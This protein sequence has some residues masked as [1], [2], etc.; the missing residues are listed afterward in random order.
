[1]DIHASLRQLPGYKLNE[2]QEAIIRHEQGPLLVIAGPGSGKTLTIILRALNLLLHGEAEPSQ[3]VICTYT[4]KAAH[5]LQSRFMDMAHKVHYQQ[6]LAEL[7]IGTIHSICN[8]LIRRYL[9]SAHLGNNYEVLDEF[10][11]RIFIF[12][13]LSDIL[14]PSIRRTIVQ[15]WEH[16]KWQ[17]AQ[18]LQDYFD[19]IMEELIDERAL[20]LNGDPF[21][22]ALSIAYTRYCKLLHTQNCVSFAAQLKTAHKLLTPGTQTYRLITQSIRYVFVDE[23]QDTNNI[24]ERIIL[25]LASATNNLCVIGDED[26]A[27]YRFRGATVRNI[28]EFSQQTPDCTVL[29]L[30]INYRSHKDIITAYATWMKGGKWSDGKH[31]FR[32][33]KDI[34]PD[35]DK[36]YLDYPSAIVLQGKDEVDETEQLADLILYLHEQRIITDY[37][38]IAFLLPSVRPQVSARYTEVF[39]RRG[40]PYFCPRARA[41]FEQEEVRLMVACFA[42]LF[43]CDGNDLDDLLADSA[44]RDFQDYLQKRCLSVLA[45]DYS[46]NHPLQQQ[47]LH[48][49]EDFKERI[50]TAEQIG[51]GKADFYLMD[52]FYRLLAVEPFATFVTDEQRLYN[53]QIFSKLLENF[54]KLYRP[55]RLTIETWQRMQH[56]FFAIYLRLQ[57]FEGLN[58]FEHNEQPFP[59]GHVQIMT[60]HQAKGLE[61]PVVIVGGMEKSRVGAFPIDRDLG[62]FYQRKDKTFEPENLIPG[63]DMRRLYYVAFSRA[64]RLLI[65]TANQ[66]KQPHAVFHDLFNHLPRWSTA[67]AVLNLLEP[68]HPKMTPRAKRH[69]SFTADLQIYETCP[70][71]Y[72]FFREYQ[73]EPAR[74]REFLLGQL[75]HQS[76]ETI[77]RMILAG[78]RQE[79]NEQT[80]QHIIDQIYMHLRNQNLYSI[81]DNLAHMAYEQVYAYFRQNRRELQHIRDAELEILIEQDDYILAGRADLLRDYNGQLELVDFKTKFRPAPDAPELIDYERQLCTY[82]YALERRY[83]TR[84]GRLL[85]YWTREPRREDA[86]M[87]IRYRPEVVTQVQQAFS[88]IVRHIHEKD[89]QIHQIPEEDTCR[90][91]DMQHY[92][93]HMGTIMLSSSVAIVT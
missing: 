24:Q 87:E 43:R 5:E 58:E 15:R 9:D 63:L 64:E 29:P 37:N 42:L 65:L 48:F 1:M 75:V 56:G 78:K 35:P 83:S 79:L 30:T 22:Q 46:A 38:Q 19:R 44:N 54:Q 67:K 21:L 51:E 73:F 80:I 62:K 69:Y 86:L 7:R 11:Q 41:Y 2:Q 82:A 10:A 89:F 53:L 84:P 77:H 55:T 61:F 8:S 4:E 92:C 52:Y 26:Q 25:A 13:H 91:C 68:Y 39:Q 33:P 14:L 31:N 49:I 36:N 34:L 72:Q 17:I 12:K 57:Q 47:L 60:I 59:S 32:H 16:N 76:I 71:Q 6:D 88:A 66:R 27:L 20:Y 45:E 3:I 23:Y 93:Q 70:R 40:I 85:L 50:N 18:K 81:E 28:L 74:P 90:H